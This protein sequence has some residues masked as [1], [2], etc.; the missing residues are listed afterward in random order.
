MPRPSPPYNRLTENK[1]T[2][3]RETAEDNLYLGLFVSLLYF[4]SENFS[5][6]HFLVLD[7]KQ[8]FPVHCRKN[9]N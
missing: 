6:L 3:F 5:Y 9:A 1:C 7:D 2:E 4:S 8:Y